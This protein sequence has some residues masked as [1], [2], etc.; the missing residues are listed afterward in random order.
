MKTQTSERRFQILRIEQSPLEKA[1]LLVEIA[2][3]VAAAI[4][5]IYTFVYQTRNAPMLQP[6]HEIISGDNHA[7]W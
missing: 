6:A 3:F 7:D 4:W 2:A 1:R 5:G